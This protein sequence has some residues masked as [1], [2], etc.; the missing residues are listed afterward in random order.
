MSERKNRALV[1]RYLQITIS[2]D[3]DELPEVAHSRIRGFDGEDRVTGLAKVRA[4]FENVRTGLTRARY[5]AQIVACDG[6]W[7]SVCGRMTGIHS[8]AMMGLPASGRKISVPGAAFFRLE[9]G[10]IAEIRSF[11]DLA[12]FLKQTALPAESA[13]TLKRIPG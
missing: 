5:T 1:E 6:E 12:A 7:V 10:K 4:Y 11:W 9:D 2:G 13:A 8:G 3:L